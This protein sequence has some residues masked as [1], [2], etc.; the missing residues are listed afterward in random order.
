MI[1]TKHIFKWSY[2]ADSG[3]RSLSLYPPQIEEQKSSYLTFRDFMDG[4]DK[5][6]EDF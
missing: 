2:S 3:N 4:R 5:L 6:S 1:E